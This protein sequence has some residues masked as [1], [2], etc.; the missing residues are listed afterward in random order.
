MSCDDKNNNVV[1]ELAATLDIQDP[2]HVNLVG[3]WTSSCK[4][5]SA[6]TKTSTQA[7]GWKSEQ[8]HQQIFNA[9]LMSE[10][11]AKTSIPADCPSIQTK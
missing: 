4:S 9:L 7:S 2:P 1:D 5:E 8:S 6:K 11:P 10:I 3:W